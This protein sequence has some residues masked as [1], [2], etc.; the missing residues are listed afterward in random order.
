MSSRHNTTTSS[1]DDAPPNPQNYIRA[2]MDRHLQYPMQ[3]PSI[4]N[5]SPNDYI[6]P[7]EKIM[8]QH[9]H[10]KPANLTPMV[11][12]L[13]QAPV[14]QPTSLLGGA[15][16]SFPSVKDEFNKTVEVL[17]INDIISNMQLG[18]ATSKENVMPNGNSRTEALSLLKTVSVDNPEW[19][20]HCPTGSDVS[21][22]WFHMAYVF[23]CQLDV[24]SGYL[25]F[26]AHHVS[27]N[28]DKVSWLN[29]IRTQNENKKKTRQNRNHI[30]SPQPRKREIDDALTPRSKPEGDA[31]TSPDELTNTSGCEG[32]VIEMN[33]PIVDVLTTEELPNDGAWTSNKQKNE[34]SDFI[35]AS[36]PMLSVCSTTATFPEVDDTVSNQLTTKE[37]DSSEA[38]LETALV[39]DELSPRQRS[40][41]DSSSFSKTDVSPVSDSETKKSSSS[42]DYYDAYRKRSRSSKLDQ[43]ENPSTKRPKAVLPQKQ[44]NVPEWTEENIKAE[45]SDSDEDIVFEGPG[46]SATKHW[47]SDRIWKPPDQKGKELKFMPP[48]SPRVKAY[49]LGIF[50][51]DPDRVT[52]KD[53]KKFISRNENTI[54]RV[55]VPSNR[56]IYCYSLQ[57]RTKVIIT[58]SSTSDNLCIRSRWKS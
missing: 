37:V 36:T 17:G 10:L 8:R 46:D 30:D 1:A 31:T 57:V 14:H 56:Q 13:S 16:N 41:I 42:E 5:Q 22:K 34:F 11:P 38:R 27:S 15:P 3:P 26:L 49:S 24:I 52:K 55:Y 33:L 45:F 2:P 54:L 39:I 44:R 25:L 18:K 53:R 12:Q 58:A 7:L 19:A 21:N 9:F 48:N 6:M 29:A 40:A 28:N 35:D 51:K 4:F 47:T 23:M 20:D 50:S 43:S 32:S